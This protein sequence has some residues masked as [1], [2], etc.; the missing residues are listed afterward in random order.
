MNHGRP[1]SLQRYECARLVCTYLLSRN[2]TTADV[3]A[4][5]IAAF[6]RLPR[7]SSQS[8]GALLS[9]L[10]TNRIRKPRFGFYCRGTTPMSKS[11]YPHRYTIELIDDARGL[12]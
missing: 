11:D 4:H 7:K 1:D 3:T 2:I 9:F 5:E 10:Y 12:V 8:I 6:F